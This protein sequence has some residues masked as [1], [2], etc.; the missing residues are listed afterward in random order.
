MDGLSASA[1]GDNQPVAQEPRA[2]ASALKTG[3]QIHVKMSW[4]SDGHAS[5][6]SF[7]RVDH[8]RAPFINPTIQMEA[9]QDGDIAPAVEA[10][11]LA[12][13]VLPILGC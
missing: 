4:I 1:M 9:R 8:G 13:A 7:G 11:N 10:T 12:Q 2:D 6:C 5:R 3:K